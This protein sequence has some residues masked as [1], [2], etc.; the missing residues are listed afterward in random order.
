MKIK[1]CCLILTSLL[2][3]CVSARMPENTAP[4]AASPPLRILTLG[5]SITAIFRYQLF[6]RDTLKQEVVDVIFVGSEGKDDNKHEGHSGWSIGQIEE[7]T[8]QYITDSNANVVLLQIGVNNM[9][10]GLG[11]KG[12]QFPPFEEGVYGQG[13]QA[14]KTLDELGASWG[15]KT[16]GSGYLTERVNGVLDK[17]TAHPNA[18]LLVVAKIP[19][20][21]LG[22]PLWKAENDDA[23]ARI[24]EFNAIL[25][26]A[27]K[28]RQAKGLKVEIVDNYALGNR[29]YG[30]GPEF[31]WGTEAQQSGDWVH[32]RP[33]AAAWK[34]MA[35]NF[36]AGL[37]RL[38]K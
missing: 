29:A 25:E 1:I 5:D 34:G 35:T 20:I 33:D 21:G 13:A 9:N 30:T 32:P 24:R 7:K 12:K 11:Q 8:T 38:M 15:D 31:T 18:P 28:A 36:A 22:N 37:R 3:G 16:Y 2:A 26:A 4:P 19:G 14:G 10:H 23:D 27:V 6:L 17:I